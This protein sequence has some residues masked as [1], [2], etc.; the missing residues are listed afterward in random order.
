MAGVAVGGVV[1]K[2]ASKS[3]GKN[4]VDSGRIVVTHNDI[5]MNGIQKLKWTSWNGYEKIILN[6]KQ[7]AKIGN[8]LYTR[9]A[10]DRMQPASL[11]SP[12]GTVGA[13]RNISPNIVEMVIKD[14]SKAE[15]IVDGVN[16]NIYKLGDIRVITENNDNLII[17][18]VRKSE[19]VY[20]YIKKW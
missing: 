18:I 7:Y 8:R 15:T 19:W 20:G 17:S 3:G 9:H 1:V 11:G 16:R 5:P 4:S 10:V 2:G 12:A 14:G 6:N 13:G